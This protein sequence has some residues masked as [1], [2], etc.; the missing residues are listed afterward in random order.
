[1]DI[2]DATLR[3]WRTTALIWGKTDCMLSINDYL[4]DCGYPDY[5]VPFRGLYDDED[6]ARRYIEDAGGELAIMR[7]P[8]LAITQKP[9]RGDIMLIGLQRQRIAGLCTGDAVAM[10]L[11]RGMCEV[12]IKFLNI[13]E[14]WKVE[15]CHQSAH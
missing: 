7:R 1:M 10:R 13:I 15:Q 3:K 14:A 12:N 5:G 2:V 6:G 8:Q 11:H 9:E 4:V